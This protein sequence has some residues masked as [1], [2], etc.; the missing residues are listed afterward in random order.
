[1]KKLFAALNLLLCFELIVQPVVPQLSLLIATDA[2]AEDAASCARQGM[3]YNAS[4]NRCNVNSN[5]A[6]AHNT[7]NQCEPGDNQ[8]LI[9]NANSTKTKLGNQ[10]SEAVDLSDTN[11]KVAFG[12]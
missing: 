9:N 2:N 1:M 12:L 3:V 5:T 11:V 10:N 6:N 4:T 7:L 8:C